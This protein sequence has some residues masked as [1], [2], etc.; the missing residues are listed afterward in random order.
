L[1]ERTSSP[2]EQEKSDVQGGKDLLLEG[3]RGR[4]SSSS[5]KSPP[6]EKKACRKKEDAGGKGLSKEKAFPQIRGYKKVGSSWRKKPE[7]KESSKRGPLM[8]QKTTVSWGHEKGKKT[9]RKGIEGERISFLVP[10]RGGFY[11]RGRGGKPA[12]S[13]QKHGKKANSKKK[14]Q[15]SHAGKKTSVS[16]QIPKG[17]CRRYQIKGKTARDAQNFRQG[18]I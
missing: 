17:A 13:E 7:S 2:L 11:Q 1:H 9:R 12:P 3:I 8:Q 14:G 15:R 18:R 16:E 6:T 4:G 5:Q 10:K